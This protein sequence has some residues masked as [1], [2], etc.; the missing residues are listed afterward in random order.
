MTFR[1]FARPLFVALSL[2]FATTA[3]APAFA[4]D[5]NAKPVPADNAKGKTAAR[6]KKLRLGNMEKFPMAADKFT[7]R[8]EER[9]AHVKARLEKA[10]KKHSTADAEKARINKEFEA[11][12][13]AI[14][15]AAKKAGSDGTV[16][17]AE[18]KEVRALAKKLADEMR[19]KLPHD[20]K[21][22][23]D[24]GEKGKSAEH[25]KAG[26]HRRNGQHG[27]RASASDL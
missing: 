5:A 19:A 1:S 16:T 21:E 17:A 27:E 25:S 23:G 2:A 13:T 8:V 3:A 26:E 24:K 15:E 9:I 10:F 12:A 6:P 7:K 4:D 20:K 18:A 22:K 11:G 14:R